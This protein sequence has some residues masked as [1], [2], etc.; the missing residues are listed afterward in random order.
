MA[1]LYQRER[2][3]LS[4]R[5]YAWI[6]SLFA[7]P[8]A[9]LYATSSTTSIARTVARQARLRRAVGAHPRVH[10]PGAPRRLDQGDRQRRPAAYIDARPR[11]RRD[12]A[13][14]PLVGEAAVPADQLGVGLHRAGD[15]LPARRRARRVPVV[16]Q[17]LRRHRGQRRQAGVLHRGAP[18]RRARRRGHCRCRRGP[19]D[20][21]FAARA[22]LLGRQ[23]HRRSRS[24]RAPAAIACCSSAT[25]S[26]A[27]C[28]ARASRRTGARR[29][30]CRSWS[31][32]SR[33]TTGCAR[34][35]RG[36]ISWTAELIHLDSEI[37]ERQAAM[38]TLQKLDDRARRWPADLPAAKRAV[39][40]AIEK[41]R[42]R[43]CA[44]RRRST[45][46]VEARDRRRVQP[47]LG[48]AVPRGLRGQQ[49]RRAGRGL[50]LRLHEPRLELPL[51][52]ADAVLPRP[53]RPHAPRTLARGRERLAPSRR[54]RQRKRRDERLASSR[55]Q[56]RAPRRSRRPRRRRPGR[57]LDDAAQQARRSPAARGA[58]STNQTAAAMTAR[59]DAAMRAS[60]AEAARA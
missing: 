42:A 23:P 22:H 54:V 31:T 26:T 20:G 38:R 8:E 32:R 9:V 50:R 52:L 41:L 6:D 14:V 55:P 47:A 11:A 49:V 57:S 25:T 37:N 21:P 30:S 28:C 10:R 27:T 18:V 2:M 24:A 45:A 1:E 7:L 36:S 17:L 51:L 56:R 15:E 29:W 59:G 4:N 33:P 53:A 39:K 5:R 16:A 35:W 44:R 58:R 34:R 19:P 3:R 13:Q 40:E 60:G 46:R 12:A 48:P 43:R